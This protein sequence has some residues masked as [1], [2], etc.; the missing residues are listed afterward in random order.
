MGM[1]KTYNTQHWTD[2]TDSS[3][4]VTYIYSLREEDTSCNT[5]PQAVCAWEQSEQPGVWEETL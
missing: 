1:S 4:L 2:E 5:E 3:L